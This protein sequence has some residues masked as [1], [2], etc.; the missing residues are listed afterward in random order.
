MARP[1]EAPSGRIKPAN[2]DQ[3]LIGALVSV[4]TGLFDDTDRDVALHL[5]ERAL[6]M[7]SSSTRMERLRPI[8]EDLLSAAGDRRRPSG[9]ARWARANMALNTAL[10]RDALDRAIAMVDPA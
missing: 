3:I 8:A 10:S 9:A 6:P 2:A 7:V 4:G 5:I 1:V